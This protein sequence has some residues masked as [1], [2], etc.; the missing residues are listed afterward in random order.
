LTSCNEY[1][2]FDRKCQVR[3]YLSD[4]VMLSAAQ[5]EYVLD[6]TMIRDVLIA[7]PHSANSE[8]VL[9]ALE[10]RTIPMSY[11][12][13]EQILAGED[14]VIAKEILEA[15]KAW[16]DIEATKAYTRLINHFT[17]DSA[18]TYAW[19]LNS[20][21]EYDTLYTHPFVYDSL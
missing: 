3:H 7:N 11:Y 19:K 5:K 17:G 20:N 14:A 8:A 18:T 21:L 13:M 16:W 1:P 10:N 12:M 15:K 2:I 9:S 6:S 4:T